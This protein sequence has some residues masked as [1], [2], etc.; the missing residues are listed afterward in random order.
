MNECRLIRSEPASGAM[1]MALD[2]ALLTSA[3]DVEGMPTLRIYRWARPT[4]SLGYFQR[5]NDREGHQ[6]SR[7]CELIRR[8]SGGGAILHHHELTYSLALPATIAKTR[9]ATQWYFDV[10]HALIAS[11][12]ELTGDEAVLCN[13][14]PK[15]PASQEPFLCFQRRASGDVL[16]NEHKIA[17]SAQRR[18]RDAIL[19]HGSVLLSRSLCAP[20]L[21]GISDLTSQL[22]TFDEL[23][24]QFVVVLAE[25]L[26]LR[27]N[28]AEPTRQE[29][30]TA[31]SLAAD[32]YSQSAW[33]LRR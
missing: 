5:A 8:P 9:P 10:H 21:D 29:I 16:L 14:P 32:K 22:M 19:Q 18:G 26:G 2:V 3:A 17:G 24:E 23:A 15:L 1:N 31:E 25:R 11:I 20:E 6:A 27:L 30:D 13:D 4:L 7:E 28:A 33:L 12:G